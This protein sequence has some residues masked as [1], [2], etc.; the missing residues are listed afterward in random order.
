MS[1]PTSA[2]AQS[3]MEKLFGTS[4][5]LG[6]LYSELQAPL[7]AKYQTAQAN[8]YKELIKYMDA[9]NAL[10]SGKELPQRRPLRPSSR[11]E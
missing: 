10:T 6:L 1:T 4:T 8:A 9:I 11:H 2:G 5:Q 3:A 7:P